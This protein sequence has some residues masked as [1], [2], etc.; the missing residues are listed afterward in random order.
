MSALIQQLPALIGVIVG[1]LGSFLATTATERIRFQR[2]Q[3]TRWE[4]RR[5]VAYADYAR[6]L[7]ESIIISQRV[8]AHAGC[9]AHPHP[10]DHDDGM[11]A[12]A[13]VVPQREAAWESVL[14]LGMPPAI[15]AARRWQQLSWEIE[16][17]AREQS[18]DCEQWSRLWAETTPD[19]QSFIGPPGVI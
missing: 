1:A 19:E 2:Q 17:F 13:A 11:A 12:L 14:L 5:V 6:A 10:L 15:E 7:K 9:D 3:A 4:E 16:R 8:V 18:N